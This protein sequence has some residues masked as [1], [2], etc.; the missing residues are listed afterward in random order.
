[1]SVVQEAGH[2]IVPLFREVYGY[3]GGADGMGCGV[4]DLI[5]D[6]A[7]QM[8]YTQAGLMVY[9]PNAPEGLRFSLAPLGKDLGV[10][11]PPV[12][13]PADPKLRYVGGHIIHPEFVA[14]YDEMG[15]GRF[16]GQPLTEIRF[17]PEKKRYE[18]FFENLGFYRLEGEPV[19]NVHLLAYGAW[20]CNRHCRDRR[21]ENDLVQQIIPVDPRFVAWT[22]AQGRFF[23]GFALT[24]AYTTPDGMIEQVFENVV[25]GFDPVNNR[26]F[27]PPLAQ[28]LGILPDSARRPSGDET[29]FF[30]A[31]QD[32]WGLE[33]PQ[34]LKDY[35]EL[36]GGWEL[37][38]PPL[39]AY[40]PS[41]GSGWRQCFTNFC[42]IYDAKAVE[43]V[44]IR[45]EPLGYSYRSMF[46]PKQGSLVQP[47]VIRQLSIQVW[48][49]SETVA[50]DREQA[51][52]VGIFEGETPVANAQPV[53]TIAFPDGSQ[54]AYPLPP[55]GEDG[56][57]RLVLPP[58]K[59]SHGVYNGAIIPYQV[60]VGSGGGGSICAQNQFTVWKER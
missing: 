30:Y 26:V 11:E 34:I 43:S 60:C 2:P 19:G 55:T 4:S 27:L 53:L 7:L 54:Q 14:K 8:Q 21:A 45:L 24:Q 6:G 28:R 38:G 35:I 50:E 23:T 46:S 57:T 47:S 42:L 40:T 1:M 9:D 56:Q 22:Q 52:W 29:M 48:E 36:R 41:R 16:P 59:S 51:F 18:Q 17:N 31:L 5:I 10:N 20:K 44:Q 37:S 58:L 13:E 32:G 39:T 15:N 33:V 12:S 49:Q 25:L 3:L